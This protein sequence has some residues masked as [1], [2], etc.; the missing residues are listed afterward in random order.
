VLRPESAA[1]FRARRGRRGTALL[2]RL[3]TVSVISVTDQATEGLVLRAL[4]G[5]GLGRLRAEAGVA[6]TLPVVL[7][8]ALGRRITLADLFTGEAPVSLA[9]RRAPPD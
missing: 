4:V 5:H 1:G 8:A 7:S 3:P 9:A 2:S 6:L